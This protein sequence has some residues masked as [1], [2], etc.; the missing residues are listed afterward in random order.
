MPY[1]TTL[2]N[3]RVYHLY[4]SKRQGKVTNILRRNQS[5]LLYRVTVIDRHNICIK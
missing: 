5:R 4:K 1:S 3:L 2:S